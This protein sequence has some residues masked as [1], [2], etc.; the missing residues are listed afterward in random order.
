MSM[1]VLC[2]HA[3]TSNW[4]QK[5]AYKLCWILCFI[6][7]LM[8]REYSITTWQVFKILLKNNHRNV[9]LTSIY[10]YCN[11]IWC[12]LFICLQSLFLFIWSLIQMN[13]KPLKGE[14]FKWNYWKTKSKGKYKKIELKRKI[15]WENTWFM[16]IKQL[17]EANYSTANILF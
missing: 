3:H 7:I 6:A 4:L 11:K 5:V 8:D 9:I 15:I 10:F 12:W 17:I 2:A 13:L 16:S 1:M 14:N